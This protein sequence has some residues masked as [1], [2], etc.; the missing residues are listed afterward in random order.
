MSIYLLLAF[1][2]ISEV[3]GSS[4]LKATNGFRRLLPS[5]GVVAGYGLAFYT[6]SIVLIQ[7]PLGTVYAVWAGL[8]TALTALIGILVY[9]EII[10]LHKIT[11][12]SLIIIGV[13]LLNL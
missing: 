2:I 9:K 12:I 13:I 11:G 5:L 10:N 3:F 7:L 1:S 4:L 8:G 6:L